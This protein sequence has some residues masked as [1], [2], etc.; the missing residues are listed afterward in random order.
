MA[1]S[2]R[3]T[4]ALREERRSAKYK[5]LWCLEFL[6]PS[7]GDVEALLIPEPLS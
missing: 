5:P 3:E 7:E 6:G 4:A 2:K 1:G